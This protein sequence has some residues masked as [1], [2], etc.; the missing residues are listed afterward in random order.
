MR[1]LVS[2]DFFEVARERSWES[3]RPSVRPARRTQMIP[4]LILI[5]LCCID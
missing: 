4:Y 2:V 5:Y 1:G 3:D